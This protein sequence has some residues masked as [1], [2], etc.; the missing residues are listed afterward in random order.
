MYVR[1]KYI[2]NQQLC[3]RLSH[4][5]E[6]VHIDFIT[7]ES[8]WVVPC[9]RNHQILYLLFIHIQKSIERIRNERELV[10]R[11]SFCPHNANQTKQVTIYFIY[12]IDSI[13]YKSNKQCNVCTKFLL[14]NKSK[15]SS[16]L[17]AA[18]L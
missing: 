5:L 10:S 12:G 6:P 15:K 16:L 14:H 4:L 17:W 9:D 13:K 7:C 3:I 1:P 2:F 18:F 11:I 8:V